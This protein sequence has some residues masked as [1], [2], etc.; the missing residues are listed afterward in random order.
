MPEI[1]SALS[2][3][4][5]FRQQKGIHCVST[6]AREGLRQPV[7]QSFI[8]M[9]DCGYRDMQEAVGGQ[10]CLLTDNTGWQVLLWHVHFR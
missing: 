9:N 1:V 2:I 10:Y 5:N 7:I 3:E 6:G 8:N 4:M